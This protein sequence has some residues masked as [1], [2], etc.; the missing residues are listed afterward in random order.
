MKN[1]RIFASFFFTFVAFEVSSQQAIGERFQILPVG[2]IRPAGWLK[3]QIENNLTGFTGRLDRLV[4]D[5]ILKDDIYGKD[6]LTRKVK[7][8]ELGAIA[9]A[10]DWQVQLLWWNSE[11]QSNWWDGYIRSAILTGSQPDLQRVKAYIKHILTTQDADGYLGI[12]DREMRYRFDYENGELWS[13]AT[14]LRG[15]L[16]WYEYSKDPAVLKAVERAVQNVMNNYPVNQSHPFFSTKPDVGG[17]SHGL[18]FTDVLETLYRINGNKALLDYAAFCYTDFST[19]T[20]NEDAQISKLLKPGLPLK[21]HGVHTYEHLRALAAAYQSTGDPEMQAALAGFLQK[22]ESTTTPAGGPVGDEWIGGKPANSTNRGYEYCSLHELMH[23]YLELYLKSGDPAFAEKAEHLFL[24]AAQ[25]ARHPDKSCIAYLKTDNSYFMTGGLN[26]DTS[27]KTQTRY[28]Y[29][30][31][32]QD[33]AVCCVPN[34]GRITPYFTQ[35]MWLKDGENL[36]ANLLG[37]A[38]LNTKIGGKNVRIREEVSFT[39]KQ[40]VRFTIDGNGSTFALR[41]R[42]PGW[43]KT[44]RAGKDIVEQDG[45]LVISRKWIGR[46]SFEISFEPAIRAHQDQNGEYFF[47]YG[48]FVLAHPIPATATET[49]SF[50]IPGFAD[51]KYRPDNLII[52]KYNTSEL[53]KPAGRHLQFLVNVVNPTTNQ[54]ENIVLEPVGRTILRQLTFANEHK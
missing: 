21:G 42:K 15:L 43:A 40:V 8:K 13:K 36:V 37:P 6:R 27:V 52:Y 11:T 47:T 1:V 7:S 48:P 51:L 34:A 20:L 32:H 5:L 14:L 9:E 50:P 46:Q 45:Y 33:A 17:L 26:G 30:P 25:G 38:E 4:P 24:N 23:S 41:I 31:A 49:R 10:G 29:S 35:Y 39:D 12:Y 22:I 53:P 18:M 3:E 28:K 44:Y 2:A 19:Q 54:N 16:A